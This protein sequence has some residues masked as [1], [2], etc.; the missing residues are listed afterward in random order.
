MLNNERVAEVLSVVLDMLG[1]KL[2]VRRELV[3]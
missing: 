3:E 2:R 1:E